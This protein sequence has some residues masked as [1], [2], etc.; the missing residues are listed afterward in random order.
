MRIGGSIRDAVAPAVALLLTNAGAI[1]R[2]LSRAR[3]AVLGETKGI[4]VPVFHA[5]LPPGAALPDLD[6][7]YTITTDQLAEVHHYFI[8][9]GFTPIGLPQLLQGL[10]PGRNYVMF[11]FDDGYANNLAAVTMLERAGVPVMLSANMTMVRSGESFWWDV[12]YRELRKSGAKQDAIERARARLIPMDPAAVRQELAQRFGDEAL[13]PRGDVDR[14]LT[15][16]ELQDLARRPTV[17]FANHTSDHR[18]LRG[19]DRASV[20]ASLAETQR[21][22][23]ELSGT[24]PVAV[25]YPY[26]VY[27]DVTLQCCRDLRFEVGFTGRFGKAMLPDELRGTA[28]MRLPRC[29]I[30]GDRP[31]AAQCE[32]THLDWRPSWTVR[33]WLQRLQSNLYPGPAPP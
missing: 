9:S 18:L 23:K 1:D 4:V 24:E 21:E 22:I 15:I 8:S 16:A 33:R 2:F 27:D 20:T 19:R 28:R 5:V 30:Y 26:G 10:D 13:R 17:S 25:T 32:S 31:I 12:L 7:A 14:P 6:P 29:V 3:R 11:T